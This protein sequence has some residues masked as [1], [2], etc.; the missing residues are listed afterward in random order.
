[1][2]FKS[3]SNT[4][5]QIVRE[6]RPRQ[7]VKN[8]FVFGPIVL[9]GRLFDASAFWQTVGA[10]FAFSFAA[11][12]TYILNDIVD[13]EKDKLHPIKSNRPIASGKLGVK[14]ATIVAFVFLILSF[15]T[16]IFVN[17][18]LF[19]IIVGYVILQFAYSFK[20]KNYII[21]DAL[22][23]SLGFI[24]RVVGGGVASST[25]IS[26]WLI[27]SVIGLSLLLAFGKRRAE[28]TV[29]SSKNID[30]KTRSTLRNYPDTLLDAMISMSAAFTMISYALFTFQT[31]PSTETP[32]LIA[33]LV[34]S[35]LSAP[36]WMMLTIPII[37]YIVGRY[38]YVIY[39]N[40]NAESPERALFEDKPL[41]VSVGVWGL[42]ILFFYYV[43]GTVNL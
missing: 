25:S 18:Y 22:A 10:F 41:L 7:W 38:L 19:Y 1:M 42:S 17:E 13:I 4:L 8:L 15:I 26:S 30:L 5:Y 29:L 2:G 43:L 9:G 34:P 21:I 36:K 40:K 37:I 6:V 3:D 32:A 24:F 12:F 27:L 35:Q 11:S 31:S 14:F 20:L 33:N 23:V 28:R 39:E 16:A